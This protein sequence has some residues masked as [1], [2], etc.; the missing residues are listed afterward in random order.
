M[1]NIEEIEEEID[2]WESKLEDDDL[3]DEQISEIEEKI[4]QLKSDLEDAW[5]IKKHGIYAYYGVSPRDF[6]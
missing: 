4:K 2:E 6:M 3:T 1:D 5:Y